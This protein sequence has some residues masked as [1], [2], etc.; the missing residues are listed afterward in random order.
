M[1]RLM[2]ATSV[3]DLCGHKVHQISSTEEDALEVVRRGMDR[4][5]AE[6]HPE[7]LAAK[8]PTSA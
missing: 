7:V 1:I 2:Q 3:C 4:H 5:H 8:S 6:K